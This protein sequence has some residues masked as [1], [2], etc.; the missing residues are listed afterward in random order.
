M[1]TQK[2]AYKV[3]NKHESEKAKKAL[4]KMGYHYNR[5]YNEYDYEIGEDIHICNNIGGDGG[6]AFY[7]LHS[8]HSKRIIVDNLDLFLNL[9]AMTDCIS[10]GHGEIWKY[11]S[12]SNNS[13]KHGYYYKQNTKRVTDSNAFFTDSNEINVYGYGFS[14]ID[15]FRKTTV[16]ELIE[17]YSKNIAVT[18]DEVLIKALKEKTKNYNLYLDKSKKVFHLPQDWNDAVEYFM[19]HDL[20]EINGYKGKDEGDY[21][22]YGC[23]KLPKE[24]FKNYNLNRE[25]TEITL[26]SGVKINLKEIEQIKK[27]LK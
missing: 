5:R 11:M 16:E 25:I 9:C 22:Q 3:K 2:V 13:F 12:G 23:A 6:Y 14:N 4:E 20:P 1:F 17:F 15:L 18:G 21:L 8:I 26:S 24:W 7:G 27:Y 10:G 19:I